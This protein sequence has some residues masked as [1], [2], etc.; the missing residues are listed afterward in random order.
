M[1]MCT[2]VCTCVWNLVSKG[3]IGGLNKVSPPYGVI[4]EPGFR[5]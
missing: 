3:L 1:R 4:Q 2:C 5:V